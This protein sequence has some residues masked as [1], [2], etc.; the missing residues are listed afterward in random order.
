MLEPEGIVPRATLTVDSVDTVNTISSVGPIGTIRTI[1]T[2]GTV[3]TSSTGAGPAGPAG[4]TAPTSPCSA[5]QATI[6]KAT[7]T[8]ATD[9]RLKDFINSLTFITVLRLQPLTRDRECF[10]SKRHGCSSSRNADRS[11]LSRLSIR[12]IHFAIHDATYERRHQPW[13]FS[14]RTKS[15]SIRIVKII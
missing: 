4:P 1:G 13:S 5:E 12:H 8:A 9:D 11:Q 10:F 2:S 15:S 6:A 3:S 14:P 7:K